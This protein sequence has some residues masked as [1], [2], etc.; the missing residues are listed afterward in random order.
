MIA[1]ENFKK[2]NTRNQAISHSLKLQE[3]SLGIML[4]WTTEHLN[5]RISKHTDKLLQ[6][7]QIISENPL[8][9]FASKNPARLLCSTFDGFFS[10]KKKSGFEQGKSERV[11]NSNESVELFKGPQDQS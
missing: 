3:A 10:Q 6:K 5:N 4:A 8:K 11:S 9:M 7:N 1:K 2:K